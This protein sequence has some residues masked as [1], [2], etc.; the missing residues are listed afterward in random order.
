[1]VNLLRHHIQIVSIIHLSFFFFSDSRYNKNVTAHHAAPI[2][3]DSACDLPAIFLLRFGTK[4]IKIR[5][6]ATFVDS[7]RQGHQYE[8]EIKTIAAFPRSPFSHHSDRI[9][10]GPVD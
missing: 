6:S 2:H 5:I 10:V 1:M 7:A 9:I 3:V 8:K 4:Y